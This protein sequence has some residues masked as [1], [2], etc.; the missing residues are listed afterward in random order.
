MG[1]PTPQKPFG[2]SPVLRKQKRET[3]HLKR[4]R[5]KSLSRSLA[6]ASERHFSFLGIPQILASENR[7]EKKLQNFPKNA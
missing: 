5:L 6:A 1:D 7:A 2:R 3:A 4:F